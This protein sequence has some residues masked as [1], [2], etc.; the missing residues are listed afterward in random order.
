MEYRTIHEL[1]SFDDLKRMGMPDAEHIFFEQSFFRY[2][3]IEKY[4]YR[5]CIEE[6]F[7]EFSHRLSQFPKLMKVLECSNRWSFHPGVLCQEDGSLQF[8]Y[9]VVEICSW[10]LSYFISGFPDMMAPIAEELVDDGLFSRSQTEMVTTLKSIFRDVVRAI[11]EILPNV[12]ESS[13]ND[14]IEDRSIANFL[15]RHLEEVV[16]SFNLPVDVPS[17]HQINGDRFC[18]IMGL[19]AALSIDE[20][21]DHLDDSDSRD[22][23]KAGVHFLERYLLLIDYLKSRSGED[24][25][26]F[27][28]M[29]GDRY[30][31]QDVV[32]FFHH[33]SSE[34]SDLCSSMKEDLDVSRLF[35]NYLTDARSRIRKD[36]FVQS[37][38]LN[39]QIF[40]EG[41][42]ERMS[43]SM[44]ESIAQIRKT[45]TSEEDNQ[46]LNEKLSFYPTT[47]YSYVLEGIDTFKGYSGYLY[48]NGLVVLDKFYRVTK[49]GIVAPSHYESI[50]V[51]DIEDFMEMSQ[52]SKSELIDKIRSHTNRSVR[53]IYH[54]PGWQNRV[55]RMME[56]PRTDYSFDDIDAILQG[57]VNEKKVTLEKERWL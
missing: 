26:T 14:C 25:Q 35:R 46:L 30:Q 5:Q 50:V 28:I 20:S 27:F 2:L 39:F 21:K 48:E 47:E 38:Q 31:S 52:Y 1:L 12:A 8:G 22:R 23:M 32:D 40:P 54:T 24:Y 41:K 3:F 51:M 42:G 37:I 19:R 6:L 4:H 44:R 57:I 18:L 43:S 9:D 29:N 13:R 53:R 45:R 56:S 16:S 36:D 33:F 17:L 34:N 49:H 7:Q 11:N 15:S 55:R 10:L